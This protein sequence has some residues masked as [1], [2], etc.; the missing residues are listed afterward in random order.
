MDQISQVARAFRQRAE[1][2]DRFL[3]TCDG[4]DPGAPDRQSIWVLGIEPGWCLA[5]QVAD[6]RRSPEAAQ[7]L[8]RYSIELQLQWPYNRNAFKLLAA[9]NG[10][11]SEEYRRFA[12]QARP[13]ERGSTG[14]F[15]GNLFPEP[16][17][18]VGV[19]DAN[20][21]DGT[22]FAT[23]AEYQTWLRAAR[24]PVMRAWIEKCRPKLVIGKRRRKAA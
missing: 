13:F 1:D 8:G 14:Y 23:K 15:K 20:A 11:P 18:N 12:E 24:F 19:W 5:D 9:L 3:E 17:N 21:V 4:G 16:F 2:A 7:Q 6:E 10:T 22:G